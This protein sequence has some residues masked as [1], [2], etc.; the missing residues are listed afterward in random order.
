MDQTSPVLVTPTVKNQET[1]WKM[2][3]VK[4]QNIVFP[5]FL[6]LYTFILGDLIKIKQKKAIQII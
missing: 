3:S 5:I 4:K 2:N 1:L 6:I